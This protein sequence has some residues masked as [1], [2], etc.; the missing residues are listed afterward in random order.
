MKN[1]GTLEVAFC[2]C[3]GWIFL[4]ITSAILI[5]AH[6]GIASKTTE[7]KTRDAIIFLIALCIGIMVIAALLYINMGI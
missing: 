1:I 7:V 5:A 3:I 2:I 4:I 6:S